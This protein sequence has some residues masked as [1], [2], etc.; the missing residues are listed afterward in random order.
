MTARAEN[1]FAGQPDLVDTIAR[2]QAYQDAGADVLFAPGLTKQEDIA[3]VIREVDRP[4]NVMMGPPGM[5][6]G[7]RELT[8]LGV[9][10]ISVGATLARAAYGEFLRAAMELR[11]LGTTNYLSSAVSAREIGALL[12]REA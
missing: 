5:A 9:R 6:L 12:R 2:L 1:F 7:V 11:D 10:R 3:T 4:V 8:Q